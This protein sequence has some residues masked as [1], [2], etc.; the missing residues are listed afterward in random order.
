M[1][2][3]LGH[4]SERHPQ[5]IHGP[6]GIH[7]PAPR[8]DAARGGFHR[9][10]HAP[11][12]S[13]QSD[14]DQRLPHPRS[15]RDRLPGTRLHPWGGYRLCRID[16]AARPRYRRIRSA[17]QLLLRRAQRILR[18]DCQVPRGSSDLGQDH[19]AALRIMQSSLLETAIPRPD[20]WRVTDLSA[21]ASQH[22]P[23]RPA[24]DGGRAGRNAVPPHERSRRSVRVADIRCRVVGVADAAS[25]SQRDRGNRHGRSVRRESLRGGSDRSARVPLLGGTREDRWHGRDGRRRGARLSASANRQVELRVPAADGKRRPASSR[26]ECLRRR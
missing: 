14:L 25:H 3:S 18:R 12:A 20:R 8:V 1:G 7:L 22:R 16:P 5:G 4:C 17:A 10:R 13:V 24:S 26:G 21:A 23:N 15:G 6:E 11:G 9:I 2:T 19:A